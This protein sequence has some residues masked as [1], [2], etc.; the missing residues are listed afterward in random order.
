MAV[1]SINITRVSSN[2]QTISLLDSLRRNTLG[3]F[4]EQTRLASGNRINAP[5][6]DPVG[7][8]QALKLTQ[9][10]ERQDQILSNIRHADS[11]LA[12]SDAAIGEVND[13]LIDAHAIASEMVN[14]TVDQ[15]QRVRPVQTL[16]GG[17]QSVQVAAMEADVV[18]GPR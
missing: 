6:E 13:L 5:S 18:D 7:A 11:F 1:T 3:L 9:V 4:L 8:A 12:I 15:S 14:T 17:D 16:D 2:L 10:L